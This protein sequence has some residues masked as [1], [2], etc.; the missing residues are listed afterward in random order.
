MSAFFHPYLCGRKATKWLTNMNNYDDYLQHEADYQ[1]LKIRDNP[2][3]HL[4]KMYSDEAS[5][6]RAKC[7]DEAI[8]DLFEKKVLD[9]GCGDGFASMD[10]LRA[11]A[12]VTAI[13]I[14]PESIKHLISIAK[15][16]NLDHHLD[17]RVM[18]AHQLEFED[19]TFDIIFGNGILHH[20]PY[21]DRAI[22]ELKRV[23]KETGHA[24]FLEPLGMNP[25]INLFRKM[26]PNCRTKDEKPFTKQELSLIREIFPNA[27]FSY[28]EYTTLFTK[29]L[30]SLKLS[31]LAGKLQKTLIKADEK[32]LKVKNPSKI[33]FAQKMSWM[34]LIKMEK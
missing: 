2:R 30:L 34:L 16:E 13:D 3:A 24:V 21:L 15:K 29:I 12:Y 4:G 5:K 6:H 20:L 26:T 33:T 32:I 28:F 27:K 14:S 19:N 7:R 31:A 25:F 18:D 23:L 17:A 9:L 22:E 10:A 11:G 8:G 1:D